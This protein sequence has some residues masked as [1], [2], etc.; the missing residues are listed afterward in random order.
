MK[1]L[2]FIALIMVVSGCNKLVLQPA[3]FSWPMESVLNI[4]NSGEIADKRYTF[5]INVKPIYYEEFA[6]SNQA[7][8]KEIRIIRDKS[9]FYYFTGAGFK[10]IYVFYPVQGG[11]MLEE[12]I[13]IPDNMPLQRPVFNMKSSGIELIDG[14]SHYLII[15]STITRS[16]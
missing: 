4:D 10:N 5:K 14:I 8:G 3:D 9:G 15:G 12:I 13:N 11:M 6:D 7:P 2:M 16:K 1:P